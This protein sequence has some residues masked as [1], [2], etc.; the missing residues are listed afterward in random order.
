MKFTV[1]RDVLFAAVSSVQRATATRVI[2]PILANILLEADTGA[3]SLRLAATDLDFSLQTTINAEI[4]E[5]GRATIASKKLAEMLAK[6][7]AKSTVTLEIDET[8]NT[9]RLQSGA[10]VFDIRTLPADEFPTLPTWA[11]VG[12]ALEVDLKTFTR[13]IRQTEFAAASSESHNVL[14][15]VFLKLSSEGLEMVAT[16]GSRLARRIE[17]LEDVQLDDAM[18][19]IIPARTL[20]EFLKLASSS[21]QDEDRARIA[22]KDGQVFLATPGFMAVSRLMDGQYPRY[23]QLIPKENSIT[24]EANKQALIASLERAAVMANERTNIV[25]MNLDPGRMI[26]AADTPDVGNS[27][28]MVPVRYEGEPLNIAFNYKFVLDALKVIESDDVR[29]ETNG[30]LAPTLFKAA[31]G[32]ATEPE[33]GYLCLVMPVQVK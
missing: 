32:E 16:D 18:S 28:D 13:T 27:Q 2:Q 10:S 20:Q 26:L 29:M 17:A 12:E 25:K 3:G 1:P 31:R 19:A 14:G 21:Q 23:E 9:A 4:N 11:D 15:G 24:A 30:A 8:V 5:P 22:L 33:D 7:P 6:L